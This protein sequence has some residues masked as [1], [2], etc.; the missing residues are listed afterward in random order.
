MK[1]MDV[2]ATT[3]IRKSKNQLLRRM[4]PPPFTI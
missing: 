1:T 3:S 4:L 2:A